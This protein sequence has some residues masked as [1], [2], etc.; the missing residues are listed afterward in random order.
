MRQVDLQNITT[1]A[2]LGQTIYTV[3][4]KVLLRRGIS[5]TLRYIERLKSMGFTSIYVND[6]LVDDIMPEEVISLQTRTQ[7]VHCV[8]NVLN[9][10][11]QQKAFKVDEAQKAVSN[12]IDNILGNKEMLGSLGD[13]RTHDDYTFFHSVNVTVLSV[14][15]GMFMHYN[16]EKLFDLGMGVLLHDVGKTVIPLEILNKPGPLTDE[17]YELIQKH[18]WEG[19]E[20]LRTNPQIKVTS[21]HVALQHHERINGTGYPRKLKG[22]DIL[23]FARIVAVADVF[24]AMTNDRCYRKKIPMYQV[25]QFLIDN[26]GTMFDS[27][28]V[29]RFIQKVAAYPQGTKV[30]LNDGRSGLVIRQNNMDPERPHV[31]LFWY[32]R[33]TLE[34]PEEVDLLKHSGLQILEVLD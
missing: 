24:D 27:V 30:L 13:I 22:N 26:S 29:E 21:A 19:F 9:N 11:K 3:D 32:D 33:G 14:L 5:L 8:H 18:C 34:K 4:G 7:A 12:I 16:H 28:V 25:R 31:R 20:I 17:E 10:V 1:G 23:D 2:T 6:G 15:M